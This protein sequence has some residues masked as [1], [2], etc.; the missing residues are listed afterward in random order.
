MRVP[1]LL[2]AILALAWGGGS[3]VAPRGG[4]ADAGAAASA[5]A[6]PAIHR[7][8]IP[9]GHKRKR[10]M[11]AYSLRHYGR[12]SWRLRRPHVIV[13]HVS[14]TSSAAAVYNTFAPD[15]PDVE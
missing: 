6:R 2:L 12:A 4:G 5:A 7:W 1:V 15:V 13:E 9:F 14:E 10:E 11:A 3:L 8:L